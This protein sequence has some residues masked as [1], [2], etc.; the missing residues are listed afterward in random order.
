ML[1]FYAGQSK[2]MPSTGKLAVNAVIVV[3]QFRREVYYSLHRVSKNKVRLFYFNQL[4]LPF[5]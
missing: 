4:L 2:S 3:T 1:M 5:V